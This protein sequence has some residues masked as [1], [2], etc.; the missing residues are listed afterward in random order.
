MKA[1]T[2]VDSEQVNVTMETLTFLT[3]FVQHYCFTIACHECVFI[4]IFVYEQLVI[5]VIP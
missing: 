1:S 5:I 4:L 2:S 3:F